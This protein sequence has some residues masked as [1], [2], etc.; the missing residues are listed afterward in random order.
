MANLLTIARMIAIPFILYFL[1]SVGENAAVWAAV[2]FALAALSD[3]LDGVVARRFSQVTQFGIVA[4]PLADRLLIISL[5]VALY[6]RFQDFFPLWALILLI[7]RD[8]LVL[9]GYQYLRKRGET[10]SVSGLGKAATAVLF[11]AFLLLILSLS[12][13][14]VQILAALVFYPGLLLYLAAA[15]DYFVKGRRLLFS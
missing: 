14:G 2:I 12:F 11:V 9:L 1:F 15:F 7:G 10:M 8:T 5:A 3:W 4:D 6:V 13:G